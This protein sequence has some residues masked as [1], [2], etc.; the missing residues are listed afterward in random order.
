MVGILARLEGILVLR[1][2]TVSEDLKISRTLNSQG[3]QLFETSGMY[4][5]SNS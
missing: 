3:W 4:E 1:R 2:P 5:S